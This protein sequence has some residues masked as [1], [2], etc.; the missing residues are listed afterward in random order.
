M[1]RVTYSS[2]NTREITSMN[3]LKSEAIGKITYLT[4][5]LMNKLRSHYFMWSKLIKILYHSR[6]K[7]GYSGNKLIK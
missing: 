4:K 2:E 5:A 6:N 3:I 1:E 7:I